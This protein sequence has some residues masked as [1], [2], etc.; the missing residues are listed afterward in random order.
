MSPKSGLK[1]N[2]NMIDP[3]SVEAFHETSRKRRCFMWRI[4]AS[5][6]A[7]SL[8]CGAVEG[9]E[10]IP[11]GSSWEYL[12]P[13]DGIDPALADPDFA[14][15]WHTPAGY[16]GPAFQG[17][18]P[19]VLGYGDIFLRPVVTNIGVP[20][21]GSRYT[22]Y[23]R[24][25]ISTTQDY[26]HLRFDILA[27]DGGVLYIDGELVERA[28][29]VGAD[30]YFSFSTNGFNEA[31]TSTVLLDRRLE[32]G[33]HVIAFSLHNLTS[34]S[35]DLGFDVRME[36]VGPTTPLEHLTWSISNGEVT[37]TKVVN[38]VVGELVI[39]DTI[40]GLLVTRV[41]ENAFQDGRW[42]SVI[43]PDGVVEIGASAFA[44]CHNL[45]DFQIPVGVTF[46]G[47]SAF[48]SCRSLTS[49]TIP[50]GVTAINDSV[51]GGC[52][53]LASITIPEGVTRIGARAFRYCTSLTT[54]DLGDN[55]ELIGDAAFESCTS[56]TSVTFTGSAP[57]KMGNA[58][59][60]HPTTKAFVEPQFAGSF[61]GVGSE[62]NGLT[63]ALKSR[64]ALFPIVGSSLH[65]T[66]FVIR[67][68]GEPGVIDWRLMGSFN[69]KDF[70]ISLAAET[71]FT[72]IAPGEYEAAINVMD[73]PSRS[74]FRVER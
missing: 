16:D 1:E 47:D 35:T 56:L 21:L 26:D 10:I 13:L 71:V 51:F 58:V 30:D 73:K 44:T 34:R 70:D 45:T 72:E 25:T 2:P 41:G 4:P 43:L 57:P 3:S 37:I 54:F 59:F 50:T 65:G 42:G 19:A 61:G 38:N 12:H 31:Q 66:D 52:W 49:I 28:N 17:P 27:D 23:F 18:G 69:L 11:F 22:A 7:L 40:E 62:W 33:E 24:T 68:T 48:Q 29:F 14:T 32:A 5:V 9:Q 63:V 60:D 64:S 15:T 53:R 36:G 67:F 74:F 46:I 6:I 20:P 39:P 8:F 55:V